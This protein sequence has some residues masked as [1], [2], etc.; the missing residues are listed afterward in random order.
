MQLRVA[1]AKR[2]LGQCRRGPCPRPHPPQPQPHRAPDGA[3]TQTQQGQSSEPSRDPALPQ[4]LLLAE[5]CSPPVL[6]TPRE[7]TAWFSRRFGEV[8]LGL[9]GPGLL[10]CPSAVAA[11][12]LR[13]RFFLLALLQALPGSNGKRALVLSARPRAVHPLGARESREQGHPAPIRAAT[14]R[15]P[16][17]GPAQLP[18]PFRAGWLSFAPGP[19]KI[20]GGSILGWGLFLCPLPQSF[21]SALRAPG[22]V[23]GP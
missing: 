9:E 16:Q 14:H 23:A 19:E 15:C 21:S 1:F 8:T 6:L 11:S 17:Q 3:E 18:H 10:R 13:R 12:V 4:T 2:A 20:P 7:G 22:C 5:P